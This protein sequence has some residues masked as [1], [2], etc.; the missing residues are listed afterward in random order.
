M[1]KLWKRT[2]SHFYID[3]STCMKVMWIDPPPLTLV[4]VSQGM[5]IKSTYDGLHVITGTT[6]NV[7]FW[8]SHSECWCPTDWNE[9]VP[10]PDFVSTV[11]FF[12]NFCLC[13]L[14]PTS[15]RRSMQ[16]M[17]WF[18][19]T[20]RLWWVIKLPI[21][22]LSSW[23]ATGDVMSTFPLWIR[24]GF[25]SSFCAKWNAEAHDVATTTAAATMVLPFLCLCCYVS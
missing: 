5:Y 12:S 20:T 4:L 14:Q 15:V 3:L 2:S 19:S 7:S 13:S 25:G 9:S 24:A 11:L 22:V 23:R 18:K 1:E 17:K 21:S 16:G 10:Y 8:L 6:E